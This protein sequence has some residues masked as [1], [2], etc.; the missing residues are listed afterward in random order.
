MK[1]C[2]EL[3]EEGLEEPLAEVL[4]DGGQSLEDGRQ[5]GVVQRKVPHTRCLADLRAYGIDLHMQLRRI[6]HHHSFSGWSINDNL[7][8]CLFS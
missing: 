2:H 1:T 6:S 7:G 4:G 5:Q 3:L 8:K